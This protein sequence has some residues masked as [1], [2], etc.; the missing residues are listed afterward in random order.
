MPLVTIALEISNGKKDTLYYPSNVVLDYIEENNYNLK[1]FIK[2]AME[3]LDQAQKRVKDK[4]GY[5]CIGCYIIKNRL[6]TWAKDY[7][8]D[9]IVSVKKITEF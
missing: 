9:L 4:F 7:N 1:D 6:L 8:E 3:S 5:Q 2:L